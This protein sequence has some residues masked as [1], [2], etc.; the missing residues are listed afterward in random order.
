[1]IRVYSDKL[2]VCDASF[3][4]KGDRDNDYRANA[5]FVL[6]EDE[7]KD[8]THVFVVAFFGAL[9]TEARDKLVPGAKFT[10]RGYV[11]MSPD[12]SERL[13]ALAF[14]PIA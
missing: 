3:A 7:A 12:G 9:A 1:M 5:L 8:G 6:A 4:E 14:C 2:I 11:G 13:T 10:F